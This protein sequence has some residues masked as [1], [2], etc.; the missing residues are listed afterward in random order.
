MRHIQAR[1][2]DEEWRVI[3]KAA[4][5]LNMDLEVFL[6]RAALEKVEREE[7]AKKKGGGK[8]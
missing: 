7:K 5:D 4:I 3:R 6:A 1:V 2:S 8:G